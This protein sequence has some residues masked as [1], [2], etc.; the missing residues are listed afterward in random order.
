MTSMCNI[1]WFLCW[2]MSLAEAHC[3]L[4]LR[5]RVLQEDAVIAVLLCETS[6]TLKHGSYSAHLPNKKGT[7][8]CYWC[9]LV[10]PDSFCPLQEH[11]RWLSHQTQCFLVTWEMQTVCRGETRP[12]MSFTRTSYASSTPMPREQRRTSQRSKDSPRKVQKQ[13]SLEIP[14]PNNE[15]QFL[16]IANIIGPPTHSCEVWGNITEAVT[17]LV[18]IIVEKQLTTTTTSSP[19]LDPQAPA[20][21]KIKSTH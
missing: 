4:S 12:W 10:T 15:H 6:V 5:T 16:L 3:K 9:A 14:T 13:V 17:I 20:T 8:G 1:E 18:F 21:L 2:R 19:T 7:R 11:Q